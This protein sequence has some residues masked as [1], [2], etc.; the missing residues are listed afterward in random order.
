MTSLRPACKFTIDD[1]HDADDPNA[2]LDDHLC[3]LIAREEGHIDDTALHR[4]RV[5]VHD[6]VHLRVTDVH[7][8]VS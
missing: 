8:L 3:T 2:D 7:V 6:S 1:D 4:G 5:L